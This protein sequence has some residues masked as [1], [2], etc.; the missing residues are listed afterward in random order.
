VTVSATVVN[1]GASLQI[2]LNDAATVQTVNVT[3]G[4]VYL[5]A[6]AGGQW[7]AT[8]TAM[9]NGGAAGGAAVTWSTTGGLTASGASATNA[10]GVA[11]A[12]VQVQG[13]AGG[14]VDVLTGCAWGTVCGSWTLYGVDASMWSVTAVSGAGQSVA[15]GAPLG[16]V[17]VMVTDGQGHP[18]QGASL[19]VHQT[20]YAWEGPCPAAGACAAAP[21]LETAVSTAISDAN[22]MAEVT[23]LE[24]AG[25]PQVVKIAIA[26]GTQ[27]FAAVALVVRN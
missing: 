25:Q 26:S 9:Q 4:P 10:Q 5:A 20:V 11:L 21:V 22:G 12:Q 1:G 17:G 19:T 24:V 15:V 6:G 27:G 14:A 23:P 16:A 7:T 13:I 18:V 2:T 3:G 8:L